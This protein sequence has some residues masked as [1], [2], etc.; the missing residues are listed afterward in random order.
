MEVCP[1]DHKFHTLA[2]HIMLSVSTTATK[3]ASMT[4]CP[5][6]KLFQSTKGHEAS[7]ICIFANPTFPRST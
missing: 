7:G 4:E 6:G 3:C 2:I 1:N 5:D